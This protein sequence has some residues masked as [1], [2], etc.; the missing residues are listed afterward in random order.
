MAT[1]S[2]GTRSM[3]AAVSRPRPTSSPS[4]ARQIKDHRRGYARGVLRALA[5]TQQGRPTA[6]VHRVLRD[7]LTPLGIRLPAATLHHLAA[8]LTAGRPVELA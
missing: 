7:S 6:Q 3:S 5:R 2:T 8:D 4:V 1:T